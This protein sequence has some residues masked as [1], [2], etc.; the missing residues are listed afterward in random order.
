MDYL[1]ENCTKLKN[2]DVANLDFSA[3]P[4]INGMFSSCYELEHL[5]VDT[6]DIT[7]A[8][9]ADGLF[10]YSYKLNTKVKITSP[11]VTSYR[12]MFNKTS[13]E[14]GAQITF[15]YSSSTSSL[16]DNMIATKSADSNVIKGSLLS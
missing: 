7:G 9:T 3:G 8:I 15:D 14:D 10:S 4:N 12:Q 5:D 6:F 13:T 16:V 1:F 11:T 2:V